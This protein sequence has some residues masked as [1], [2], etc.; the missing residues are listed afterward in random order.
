MTDGLTGYAM[1]EPD[2]GSMHGLSGSEPVILAMS[3]SWAGECP[4][5]GFTMGKGTGY[6]SLDEELF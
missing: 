4:N 6:T 3:G 2:V 5:Y 1:D